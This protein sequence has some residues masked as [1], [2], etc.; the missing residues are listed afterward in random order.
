MGFTLLMDAIQTIGESIRRGRQPSGN[1]PDDSEEQGGE[2]SWVTTPVMQSVPPF[3]EPMLDEQSVET[4]LYS[5][6][7]SAPK[8][9]QRRKSERHLLVYR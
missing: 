2:V 7:R 3:C 9:V 6:D 8:P 4:A 1:E 5:L